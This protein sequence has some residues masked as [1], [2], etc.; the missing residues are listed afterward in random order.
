MDKKINKDSARR[1]IQTFMSWIMQGVLL[2]A[3]AWTIHWSWAWIL[4]AAGL[5]VL[6]FNLFVLPSDVIEERGRKKANVKRWDKILTKIILLPMIGV[7]ILSGLDFHYSWTGD[8]KFAVHV[9][10]IAGFV[11]GS[12][13]MTWSMVSNRFFSTLVRIQEERG[14][15]VATGGPYRYI[16]HPGYLGFMLMMAGT[17]VALGTLYGLILSA[18]IALLFVIRTIKED[19]TLL[20]ELDGYPDYARKVRYRLIPMIW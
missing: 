17:P 7:Y 18:V 19:Q 1:I 20:Q 11:C 9:L 8:L 14:H 12:L 5:A 3:S 16:R 10:G 6:V 4:L 15:T 2:F 13:L